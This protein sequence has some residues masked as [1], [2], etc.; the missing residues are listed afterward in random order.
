MNKSLLIDKYFTNKLSSQEQNVVNQLLSRD[1]EFHK[2]FMYIRDVQQAIYFLERRRLKKEL[3]EVEKLRTKTR[4]SIFIR[5]WSIA[6][7]IALLFGIFGLNLFKND[8]M[9]NFDILYNT[10][11]SPYE[12]VVH[13]LQRGES[14][15]YLKNIA[16]TAYEKQQ[17][18]EAADAF[19]NAYKKNEEPELLFYLGVSLLANKEYNEG[20]AVLKKCL[21]LNSKFE[22]QIHWYLGLSHIKLNKI[23]T[24]IYYLKLVGSTK[25]GFKQAE[26]KILL[27]KLK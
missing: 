24:A 22:S 20:N 7:S 9:T 5:K 19:F 15:D 16:F 13:P 2:E 27:E 1:R 6:A 3:Q 8:S 10:H 21:H 11:F 4:R 14:N 17:Y 12:N 25:Q 26:T 18:Q 23:E